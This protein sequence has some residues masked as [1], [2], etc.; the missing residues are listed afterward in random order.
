MPEEKGTGGLEW[1]PEGVGE[2]VHC[3]KVYALRKTKDGKLI[4]SGAAE[5]LSCGYSEFRLL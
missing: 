5:C 4:P 3:G 2:C 1:S